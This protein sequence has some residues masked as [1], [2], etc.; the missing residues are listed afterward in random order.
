MLNR[1]SVKRCIK[2]GSSKRNSPPIIGFS[3]AESITSRLRH[4]RNSV[5][6]IHRT[7]IDSL[8]P[9]VVRDKINPLSI[10]RPTGH[11]VP[12]HICQQPA[13]TPLR[14]ID[15]IHFWMTRFPGIKCDL[16][17]IRGPVWTPRLW[18]LKIRDLHQMGPVGVAD[19][20]LLDASTSG[21]EG[22]VASIRRIL[23]INFLPRGGNQLHSRR[24]RMQ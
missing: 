19:P 14:N 10:A 20:D 21:L 12:G 8:S 1:N 9:D 16:L 11:V 3:G 15:G 23:K 18:I 17:P 22:D 24:L 6:A 4:Q 7:T 2:A 5:S 13:R